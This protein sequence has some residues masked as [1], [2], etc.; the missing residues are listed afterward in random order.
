M[1]D[2][3]LIAVIGAFQATL[4]AYFAYIQKKQGEHISEI[5]TQTNGMS[6]KLEEAAHAKGVIEEKGRAAIE[7]EETKQEENKP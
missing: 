7:K 1:S 5:K 3:V 6:R 2:P 4:V